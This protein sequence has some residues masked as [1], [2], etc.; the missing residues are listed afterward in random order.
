MAHDQLA[1][2]HS[3]A[4]SPAPGPY[5]QS[6]LVHAVDDAAYSV[7]MICMTG[8][9]IIYLYTLCIGFLGV[10]KFGVADQRLYCARVNTH[11]LD[12]NYALHHHV[13]T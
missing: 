7:L 9:L 13:T 10:H 1:S 11:T 12:S 4:S 8:T 6:W 5:A 2:V 3:L